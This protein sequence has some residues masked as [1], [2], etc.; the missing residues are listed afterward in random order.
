MT[1]TATQGLVTSSDIT[2]TLAAARTTLE[3]Y[4][5]VGEKLSSRID[6]LAAG[7]TNTLAEAQRTLVRLQGAADNLRV[8]LR[9]DAP[10]QHDL[11]Q[12]FRQLASTAE[13]TSG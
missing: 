10:L 11:E 5:A 8:M 2:N 3:Q 1:C 12:L 13:N 9:P 4:R 7:L 6:P